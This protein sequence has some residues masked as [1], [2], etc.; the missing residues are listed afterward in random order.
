MLREHA[1]RAAARTQ[2]DPTVAAVI[3]RL[4]PEFLEQAGPLTIV[5]VVL[6]ARHDLDEPH[7][8]A[9][10]ELLERLARQRLLEMAARGTPARSTGS[11]GAATTAT[12]PAA[13]R[14]PPPGSN[15]R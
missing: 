11:P 8:L 13:R 5:R 1:A 10:P 2:T 14:S 6:Q 15:G 4:T 7:P 3:N 9:L 12:R